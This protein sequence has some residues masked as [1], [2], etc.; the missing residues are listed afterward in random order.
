MRRL[1]LLFVTLFA[2]ALIAACGDGDTS[3]TSQE[4]TATG[5]HNPADI[6]FAQGMIPHHRQ[7]IEMA[8]LAPDRAQN[9]RVRT[10]ARQV[11]DAQSPEI[12]TM[13]GWLNA[14]GQPTTPPDPHTAPGHPTSDASLP[15]MTPGHSMDGMMS[16]QDLADLRDTRGRDFDELFL[17]MMIEH[18]QGAIAAA[19]T[20][21]RDG[22]H[23][24]TRRLAENIQ[25][26]QTAEI[27]VM[28]E[29]LTKI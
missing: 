18:H 23:T 16:A 12:T 14:W 1:I 10:L 29:L 6:A 25:R 11:R 2:I 15:G 28:Q 13:V 4:D 8:D 21:E 9:E 17:A 7:A 24:P 20:E 22:L 26:T 19:T 5:A 3:D 27:S